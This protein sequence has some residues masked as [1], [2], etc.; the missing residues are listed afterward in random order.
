MAEI[1]AAAADPDVVMWFGPDEV[2]LWNTWP[3]LAMLGG[4]VIGT[5]VV[6]TKVFKFN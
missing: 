5:G 6:A 4:W 1:E 3:Q 2:D